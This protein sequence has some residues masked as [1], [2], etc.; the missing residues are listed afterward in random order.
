MPLRGRTLWPE[1]GH[2]HGLD[3]IERRET[4]HVD[5]RLCT[6]AR[7]M[8]SASAGVVIAWCF[9]EMHRRPAR[10]W[11]REGTRAGRSGRGMR[12]VAVLATGIRFAM[13]KDKSPEKSYTLVIVVSFVIAVLVPF[14]RA[15]ATGDTDVVAAYATVAPASVSANASL[16]RGTGSDELSLLVVGVFLLGLG[17]VLRRVA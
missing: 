9:L 11:A 16:P 1:T 6:I 5:P 7:T 12:L 10:P 4:L 14:V 8:E 15:L 13:T 17:S 2:R 3:A